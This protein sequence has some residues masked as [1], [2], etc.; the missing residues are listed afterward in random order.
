L[1]EPLHSA[2]VLIVANWR[3]ITF[4]FPGWMPLV[5]TQLLPEEFPH[6][7]RELAEIIAEHH[8]VRALSRDIVRTRISISASLILIRRR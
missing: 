2:A 1:I 6:R 3:W 5:S 7:V 4:V 8:N